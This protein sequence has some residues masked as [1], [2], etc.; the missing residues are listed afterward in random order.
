MDWINRLRQE[1]DYATRL[2]TDLEFF[3]SERLKIRPK[4]GSLAP[5]L[6]NPAQREL[7]RLIEE[8]KAKTGRVRV[9][10]LTLPPRF[11]PD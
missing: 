1:G 9:V 10:V 5:F 8:Q 6:F 4:A 2:A 11:Y 7:H 3:A